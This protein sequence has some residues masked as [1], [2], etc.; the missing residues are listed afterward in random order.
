PPASGRLGENPPLS[1][2]IHFFRKMNSMGVVG[3]FPYKYHTLNAN[4]YTSSREERKR[5]RKKRE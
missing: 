3:I 2:K 5:K 4:E 1:K